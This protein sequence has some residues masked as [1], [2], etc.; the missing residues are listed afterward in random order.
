[1][2]DL[3]KQYIRS[4]V[5][6]LTKTVDLSLADIQQLDAEI[7]IA[8]QKIASIVNEIEEKY[9]SIIIELSSRRR[10]GRTIYDTKK[11]GK[12]QMTYIIFP[13]CISSECI[14]WD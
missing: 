9:P 11:G 4:G 6:D 10:S 8:E 13:E 5:D 14:I 12:A 2:D 7:A 1:M 3:T